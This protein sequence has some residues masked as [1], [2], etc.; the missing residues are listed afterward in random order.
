MLEVTWNEYHKNGMSEIYNPIEHTVTKRT[1]KLIS[2]E[3][4]YCYIACNGR[5]VK[6]FY[7]SVEV[8]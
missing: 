4:D 2:I 3:N 8:K 1:G 5:I 7:E 6:K